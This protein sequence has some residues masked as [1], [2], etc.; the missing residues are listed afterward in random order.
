MWSYPSCHR[1]RSRV[2]PGPSWCHGLW[3]VWVLLLLI[4]GCIIYICPLSPSIL[5]SLIKY[6]LVYSLLCFILFC[7]LWS[8]YQMCTDQ[9]SFAL[10]SESFQL[11]TWDCEKWKKSR[12]CVVSHIW[13]QAAPSSVKSMLSLV[14]EGSEPHDAWPVLHALVHT[15]TPWHVPAIAN[16]PL[17]PL[18]SITFNNRTINAHCTDLRGLSPLATSARISHPL[19]VE[20][21][22]G[23]IEA[24][25]A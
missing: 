2:H 25:M 8:K 13:R 16:P 12:V 6:Y 9:L 7:F 5:S 24:N 23:Y 22:I 15:L 14:S 18:G 1:V 4:I 11:L 17:T 3:T 10:F 19:L 21:H 20:D